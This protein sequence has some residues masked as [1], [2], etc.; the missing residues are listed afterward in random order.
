[1]RK[2][3]AIMLSSFG[4]IAV[5]PLVFLCWLGIPMLLSGETAALRDAVRYSFLPAVFAV[6]FVLFIGIPVTLVLVHYGKLRWWP[7]GM[8]GFVAA[9]LPIAL[10]GPGGG[11]GHSSGGNWHGKPVDFIV[12]GEP[13]LYGWLNY[14]ESTCF[15]G[16][17]GLVGATVFYVLWRHTMGP[18]N[19]FKPNP[20]RGSA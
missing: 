19:S 5:Q 12:N 13:S 10:S 2:I 18:N 17:H 4:A 1:M 15:F 14:L 16:L 3:N 6:P 20:L 7:L 9:A 11:A 8:I